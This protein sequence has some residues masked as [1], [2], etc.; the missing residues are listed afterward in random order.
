MGYTDESCHGDKISH[1]ALPTRAVER[2]RR[3]KERVRS[4][5]QA[6]GGWV[7][8][9]RKRRGKGG[10]I[11]GTRAWGSRVNQM[12]RKG[13]HTVHEDGWCGPML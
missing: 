7:P 1:G 2:I 10:M 8:K 5:R 12:L 11:W 6:C 3:G 13:E 4:T 9:R